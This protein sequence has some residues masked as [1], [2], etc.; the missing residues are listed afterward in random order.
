MCVTVHGTFVEY[1]TSLWKSSSTKL[2][3]PQFAEV[4]NFTMCRSSLTTMKWISMDALQVHI[5][6]LQIAFEWMPEFVIYDG[7]I[8][9]HGQV[10][11]CRCREW[12]DQ[13]SYCWHGWFPINYQIVWGPQLH[14]IVAFD[15]WCF[16]KRPTLLCYFTSQTLPEWFHTIGSGIESPFRAARFW[17][18]GQYCFELHVAHST[19]V[20]RFL[21]VNM[22]HN[23]F[24][25]EQEADPICSK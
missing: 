13:E 11:V 19:I 17:T 8:N 12:N 10:L 15:C 2:L 16:L 7:V 3:P 1:C 22:W 4:H 14:C 9:S 20:T 5:S 18:P 23:F 21:P 25:K 24:S 6:I